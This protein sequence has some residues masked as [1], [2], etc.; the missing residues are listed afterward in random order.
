MKSHD[1]KLWKEVQ[2]KIVD[3]GGD[4]GPVDGIPGPK[5]ATGVLATYEDLLEPKTAASK[6]PAKATKSAGAPLEVD[7]RSA[8][9]LATLLPEVQDTFRELLLAGKAIAAEN[10]W[11][12]RLI[13][14]TRTYAEQNALYAQGRTKKGRRVTNARGGYSRHNFGIAGDFGVFATKNTKKTSDDVYLDGSQWSSAE[15]VHKAVA[16]YAKEK[17]LPIQWGG[18]WESFI[19]MPHFEYKNG[20]TTSQMRKLVSEGKSVI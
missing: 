11:D 8:K 19:D 3:L 13:S 2:Q 4:P 15:S 6:K 17:G 16:D 1:V 14:G 20:K 7:E 10:G 9:V 5:T 18:D 12:Y